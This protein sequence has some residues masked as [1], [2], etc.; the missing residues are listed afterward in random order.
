MLHLCNELLKKRVYLY[1][2]F[3][4][5][6]A[7]QRNVLVETVDPS[8]I[9]RTKS[10][11]ILFGYPYPS[12]RTGLDGS[13][14]LTPSLSPSLSPSFQERIERRV[15]DAQTEAFK[16]IE[17]IFLEMHF[18]IRSSLARTAAQQYYYGGESLPLSYKLSNFKLGY[19][20][21]FSV[22][23]R[24]T[25]QLKTSVLSMINFNAGRG[26]PRSMNYEHSHFIFR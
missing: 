26:Q 9:V 11:L 23:I 5:R 10:L 19:I 22:Y 17:L 16:S 20:S 21:L 15:H 12:D 7:L 13:T 4:V 24:H 6:T 1:Y 25:E 14:E 18:L 3:N 8:L 2:I